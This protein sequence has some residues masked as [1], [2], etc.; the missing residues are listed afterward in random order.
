MSVYKTNLI[1]ITKQE[2]IKADC[3]LSIGCQED[4]KKYFKSFEAKEFYTLDVERSHKPNFLWDMNRPIDDAEPELGQD[5]IEKFDV[6]LALNLWEYIFDPVTAHRNILNFL[7][8]GGMYIG[9]YPFIYPQHN[10]VFMDFLRYT[11]LGVSKILK[12]AGFSDIDQTLI[13]SN[14]IA[15]YYLLDS[16]KTAAHVDHRTIGTFIYAKK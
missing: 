11:P 2:E 13:L 3:I 4:D 1:S 7:K 16:A 5:L 8:R 15:R 10:P 14:N 9:N 12:E 6:V